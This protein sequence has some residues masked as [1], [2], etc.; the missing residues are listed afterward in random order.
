MR[1]LSRAERNEIVAKENPPTSMPDLLQDIQ[2]ELDRGHE[3]LTD[4]TDSLKHT[5][6]E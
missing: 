5:E 6:G 3:L 4:V 1:G 2:E